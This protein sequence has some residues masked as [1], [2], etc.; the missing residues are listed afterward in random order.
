MDFTHVKR[1]ILN[2]VTP[3]GDSEDH[4]LCEELAIAF[5]RLEALEPLMSYNVIMIYDWALWNPFE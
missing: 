4:P 3:H 5:S 1:L 2:C